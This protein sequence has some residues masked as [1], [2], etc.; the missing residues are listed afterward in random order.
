MSSSN[1]RFQLTLPLHDFQQIKNLRSTP[2][3]FC[4]NKKQL[5]MYNIFFHKKLYLILGSTHAGGRETKSLP[6]TFAPGLPL[7]A[8]LF[9]TTADGK[10]IGQTHHMFLRFPNLRIFF[11]FFFSYFFDYEIEFSN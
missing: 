5:P 3:L 4:F 1:A 8:N 2:T 6:S 11:T 9:V 7:T 10:H